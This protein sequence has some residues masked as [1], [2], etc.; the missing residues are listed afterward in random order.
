MWN[1]NTVAKNLN[2]TYNLLYFQIDLAGR[3]ALLAYMLVNI[4]Q[5]ISQFFKSKNMIASAIL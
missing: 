4:L 5:R 3:N 2:P 1:S